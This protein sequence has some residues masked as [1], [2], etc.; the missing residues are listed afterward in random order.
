MT[1]T[2]GSTEAG[3]GESFP[4]LP[5]EPVFSELAAR[6]REEGRTVPGA[7]DPLW[8]TLVVRPVWP[9]EGRRR[10]VSDQAASDCAP[11]ARGPG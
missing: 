4:P 3:G 9:Q 11:P 10:L 6:W 2:P 7:A 1:S 5:E 8:D